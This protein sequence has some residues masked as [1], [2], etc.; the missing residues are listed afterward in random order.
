ML[1]KIGLKT[2]TESLIYKSSYNVIKFGKSAQHLLMSIPLN[3]L[4]VF[5]VAYK[6][7]CL[8]QALGDAIGSEC[9]AARLWVCIEHTVPRLAQLMGRIQSLSLSLSPFRPVPLFC[10]SPVLHYRS[11]S[12]FQSLP[13]S[14]S[15]PA[16][17][18]AVSL[19]RSL[20][21]S[22]LGPCK[23]ACPGM[24]L[25][26]T[27]KP[28]LSPYLHDFPVQNVRI[29]V[30]YFDL[31]VNVVW[32][33]TGVAW[34]FLQVEGIPF[35]GIWIVLCGNLVLLGSVSWIYRSVGVFIVV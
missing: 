24:E 3:M 10:P 28:I 5:C 4:V 32:P 6:L 7:H 30:F 13:L 16:S 19:H 27:L 29:N 34:D 15:Y 35:P 18:T 14:G 25:I 31:R 11:L 2:S 23:P 8:H 1:E 17:P 22:S 26:P 12:L 20:T 9:P 21:F 33:L